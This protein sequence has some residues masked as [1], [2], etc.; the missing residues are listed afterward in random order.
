VERITDR[1]LLESD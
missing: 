1:P